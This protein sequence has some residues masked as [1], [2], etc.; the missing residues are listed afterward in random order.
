LRSAPAP[1]QRPT[2][3]VSV[4]PQ[5]WLV[6]RLADGLV[7]V[8][9]MVPPGANPATYEP[10]LTERRA[11]ARASLYVKVGHPHFPFEVAWLDRLLRDRPDLPVVD[12]TRGITAFASDPHLWL[13]P[14][15]MAAM[16]GPLTDALVGLLPA[17]ADAIRKRESVLRDE[18]TATDARLREIFADSRG[19]TFLALH[20]A[21]GYLADEYGLVQL[22]IQR[23]NREPDPRWLAELIERA[24]ALR[25]EVVFSQPHVDPASARVV[26]AAIGA[27]VEAIDP[28]ARAWHRNLVHVAERLAAEA[29]G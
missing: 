11:F 28:L 23:E 1:P 5:A 14:S 21:W 9:V 10:E 12:G 29:R 25:I 17:E 2:V 26:A 18:L 7:D 3:A 20:P 15:R 16:T 6:E 22:A 27:R 8:V 4:P 19:K 13:S 24:R